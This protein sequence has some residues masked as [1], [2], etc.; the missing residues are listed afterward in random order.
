MS[1]LERLGDPALE[2]H[3]GTLL[4]RFKSKNWPNAEKQSS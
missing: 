1:A 2:F 3:L 4:I